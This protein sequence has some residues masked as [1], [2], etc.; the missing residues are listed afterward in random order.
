MGTTNV[1]MAWERWFPRKRNLILAMLGLDGTGKTTIL[2]QLKFSDAITTIPTIGF[3]IENVVFKNIEYTIWDIGG[4]DKIRNL[5]KHYLNNVSGLI[6]VIDSSDRDRIREAAD[7]MYKILYDIDMFK[8]PILILANKQ[9]ITH[10]M[11]PSEVI[12]Q[13]NLFTLKSHNWNVRACCGLNGE[14]LY[15]G[16]DWMTKQFSKN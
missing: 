4:Q 9:D 2:Y 15:Q 10:S 11:C 6:Y 12:Q 14:G 16:L 8:K 7:E 13:M 5:W 1:K 3:N